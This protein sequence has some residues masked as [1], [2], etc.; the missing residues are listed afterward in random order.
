MGDALVNE[1]GR[2][3]TLLGM[4]TCTDRMLTIG[5]LADVTGASPRSLRHYEQFGILRPQR[6]PNGYRWYEPTDVDV[7]ARVKALLALGLP[8]R[9][10]R[11][12][13]DCVAEASRVDA[14]E[15]T[16]LREA[17]T[18]QLEKVDRQACEI[19]AQRD[20]IVAVLSGQAS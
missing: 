7:V 1:C 17:L 10:I 6:Q 19:L 2:S 15:C 13:V 18:G 16:E 3:C 9:T 12:L 11:D 20:A 8:L 5:E 4:A 14:D